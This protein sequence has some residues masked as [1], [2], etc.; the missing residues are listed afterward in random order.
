MVITEDS[1]HETN[2]SGIVVLAVRHEAET[3]LADTDGDYT[4]LQTDSA[5]RLKVASVSAGSAPEVVVVDTAD[6]GVFT[7]VANAVANGVALAA[8]P[9]R[10]GAT[11]FND[12]V[13]TGGASVK[14]ALGFPSSATN[15]TV[16]LAP[17]AYYEVPYGYV[18]AI[19]RIATAATGNLRITEIS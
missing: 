16:N 12:D 14:L 3:S 9:A 4:V 18:G 2:A 13:T 6:T 15:F 17:Q 5:G 10:K 8:N 7:T 19:N 11:I 1:I